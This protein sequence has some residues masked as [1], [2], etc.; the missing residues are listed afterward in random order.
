MK[1]AIL[2]CLLSVKHVA[3][4]E[5][6][7]QMALIAKWEDVAPFAGKV[8]AFK[9][10]GGSLGSEKEYVLTEDNTLKF[11]YIYDFV[12]PW[13]REGK[14]YEITRLLKRNVI[15]G[16]FALTNDSIKELTPL[17][18]RVAT[19]HEINK[20]CNAIDSNMAEFQYASNE[21]FRSF[22]KKSNSK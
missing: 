6:S 21:E 8:I 4:M 12:S 10:L 1:I 17:L 15:H 3:G 20:I 13:H 19:T 14:G 2:L 16:V 9:I 22:L 11:G 5:R 7:T 18:M